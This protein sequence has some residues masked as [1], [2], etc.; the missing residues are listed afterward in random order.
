MLDDEE[1]SKKNLKRKGNHADV[2]E[3]GDE[4]TTGPHKQFFSGLNEDDK[5]TMRRIYPNRGQ[6]RASSDTQQPRLYEFKDGD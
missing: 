5:N 6:P 1:P 3:A 2:E 4:F